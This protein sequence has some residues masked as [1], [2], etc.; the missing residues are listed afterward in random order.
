MNRSKT[1]PEVT[2]GH[3]NRASE[4]RSV[5]E[6][7]NSGCRRTAV[8]E[9]TVNPVYVSDVGDVGDAGCEARVTVAAK[10]RHSPTN[11]EP[12]PAGIPLMKRFVWRDRDPSD[13]WI[14]V[15][16][17]SIRGRGVAGVTGTTYPIGG[18]SARA[19]GRDRSADGSVVA[20]RGGV[21]ARPVA[22]ISPAVIVAGPTRSGVADVES[23][24]THKGR[25]PIRCCRVG[26]R[27]PCPAGSA[28]VAVVP[29]A[30][31]V[32][33]PAPRLR[34]YPRPA[35]SVFPRPGT[36]TIRHPAG[37]FVRH[38]RLPVARDGLPLAVSSEV[39]VACD[40]GI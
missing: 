35:V 11:P 30:V 26:R 32:G 24:E 27:Q 29:V 12:C 34:P 20:A 4:N 33:C 3:R 7:S 16:V 40:V 9:V 1:T 36:V 19:Q 22:V 39:V 25:R 18:G 10:E 17:V 8:A 37:R 14:G 13:V 31:V 28:A 38:P 2:G 6:V 5:T 15:G 23:E 21:A